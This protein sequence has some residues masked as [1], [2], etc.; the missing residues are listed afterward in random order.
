[1]Q[2]ICCGNRERGD[3]GA[4]VLVAQR[5]RELGI[6]TQIHTGEALA[7][8]LAWA[9]SED[10]IVVDAML[11]G[12]AAGTTQLWEAPLPSGFVNGSASTHGLGVAEAIHLAQA[13]N[14][15]PKRLRILGIEGKQFRP[16]DQISPEVRQ[17]V[18]K[19]ARQIAS[20]VEIGN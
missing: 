16:G 4:A 1:M 13:L 12:A 17:A 9:E 3:D 18:E 10:V 8:I 2:I 7:L 6:E 19:V 15:L 14:R 5:L 11:T 20:E